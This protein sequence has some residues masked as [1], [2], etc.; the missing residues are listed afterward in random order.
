MKLDKLL[1]YTKEH[2]WVRVQGH[3]ATIG[4]TDHAQRELGD[5][6]F[7]ELEPL[8]ESFEQN[9]VF[10]SVEA[11]KAVADLFMPIAGTI[12][13]HNDA[14]EDDPSLVNEDP[15]GKG[16]LIVVELADLAQVDSLLSADEYAAMV[17]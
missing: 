3:T 17:G 15:Y 16:W 7:V 2:E 1:R 5:I 6:V 8:Q 9:E 12:T 11:V 4:I 10:G 13:Q 14:L